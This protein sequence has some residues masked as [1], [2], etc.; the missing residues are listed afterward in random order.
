MRA[1]LL[2]DGALRAHREGAL[3]QAEALYRELLT[4]K[5]LGPN[6]ALVHFN[7]GVVTA[8]Q[9]R[10]DEAVACYRRAAATRPG[11]FDAHLNLGAALKA[12]GRLDQAAESYRRAAQCQPGDFRAHDNLGQVLKDLGRLDE[13]AEACRLANRL[14]P[15]EP[16]PWNSL[17]NIAQRRGRLDEAAAAYRQAIAL[18]PD[19][20]EAHYNLGSVLRESG[21]HDEAIACLRRAIA[22]KPDYAE[23]HNS[24]GTA[25]QELGETEAAVSSHRQALALR[26]DYALARLALA[27]STLPVVA[28]DA[29]DSRQAVPRFT[30]ALAD[31]AQCDA[32]ALGEAIGMSQPFL[33]AYRPGNHRDSLSCYGDLT[34]AAAAARWNGAIGRSPRRRQRKRLRLAVM[35]GHTRRHSV[36]DVILKGIVSHLDRERFELVLYSTSAGADEETR[37][38]EEQAD[39]FVAGPL[40]VSDWLGRVAADRP[41]ILVYPEIGMDPVVGVLAALRL[42][43]L[44]VA[45]WGHPLTTGLPTIDLFLSGEL[46]ES[47]AADSHYR[48]KLVRLPGTG[49]CTIPLPIAAEAADLPG[50]AAAATV[51]FA[52]CQTPFKFD[53][54][55][56]DLYPRIA[57]RVGACEFWLVGPNDRTAW[58]TRRVFARLEAAFRRHGLDPAAHLRLSAA[59]P[60]PRFLGFLDA[61]DVYLDCPSFSGYTTAWQAVGRGLPIVTLEGEYLRHRLAAG[62]LRR[63]GRPGT[64]AASPEEYEE[65]AVALAEESRD[66]ELRSRRRADLRGAAAAADDDVAVVRALERRLIEACGG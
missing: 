11:Y 9:G 53:P 57:G 63:I 4:L 54:A 64:I 10:L 58:A 42:A 56:D 65:I 12:T 46:L 28:A 24:L 29:A 25:L 59:L 15:G 49:C 39:I 45:S 14:K 19:L 30:A 1:K 31:L 13:A 6:A 35:S 41:D 37:W 48:E 38:A 43:P 60:R 20:A 2:F 55:D 8:D 16:G 27:M 40:P 66:G 5:D 33:L 47:P 62:L 52:L 23:A 61:M 36:W 51:R 17:G 50:V 34:A 26:P 22:L 18:R 3:A 44:Q 32:R 21:N 7:L